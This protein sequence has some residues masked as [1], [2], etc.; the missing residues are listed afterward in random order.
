MVDGHIPHVEDRAMTA[1]LDYAVTLG[2]DTIVL[3]GDMVDFYHCST[4]SKD[5]GAPSIRQ[6]A[7]TF[8]EFLDF[9]DV[10]F[11]NVAPTNRYYIPGNHERRLERYLWSNAAA[12]ANLESMTLPK[13]LGLEKHSYQ[14]IDNIKRMEA[15]EAPFSIGNL[16]YFHG[17]EFK[18][19]YGVVN[20]AQVVLRRCRENCI[21]GH[22]HRTQEASESSIAGTVKAAWSVGQLGPASPAYRP[23]NDWNHGFAVI[24]HHDDDYFTVDN[25]RIIDGRVL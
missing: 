12:I 3:A 10:Y 21:F 1:T 18:V 4:F 7:D 22:F 15:G 14:Y 11:P 13:L 23:V 8:K 9:L 24:T 25:K 6:E 20:V 19:S 16:Y 17:D 2:V 5:P